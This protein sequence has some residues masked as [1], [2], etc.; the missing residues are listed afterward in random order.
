MDGGW[1]EPLQCIFWEVGLYPWMYAD[2][3]SS[4]DVIT[5]KVYRLASNKYGVTCGAK[6]SKTGDPFGLGYWE[7][8][9]WIQP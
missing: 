5:S 6:I 2:E 7:S 4:D 3:R 1:R 9:G 8:K